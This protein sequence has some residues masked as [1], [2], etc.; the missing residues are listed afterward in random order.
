MATKLF[1]PLSIR[2]VTLRNRIVASPMWQYAGHDGRPNDWHLMNLG[3]LADGGSALVM[4]EGT[5]VQRGTKGTRGDIGIW[6]DENLEAYARIVAL[7]KTCGAIPG[8]QLIHP[9]R[10]ARQKPPQEGRG[11]QERTSDVIPEWDD[12]EVMGPS[13]LPV[14]PGMPL[15]REM[16]GVDIQNAVEAFAAAAARADRAGY[17]VL[18]LHGAH[19][20]L[21][22]SFLSPLS[23]HRTDRYG[24]NLQNRAR[25][26]LETVE[27]VRSQWPEGKPLFV[28][29]SC[30]DGPQEGLTIED[31]FALVPL[32]KAVGVDLIDCSSGGNGGSPLTRGKSASYGYQV[33]LSAAI[34][35]E[36]GILT[37]TVGLIVHAHQAEQYL[38]EGKADLIALA[39]ELIYNPN[40][41]MDAAL[42]LGE[43]DAFNLLSPREAFWLERRAATTPGLVPSTFA[44]PFAPQNGTK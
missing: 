13:P 9:G 42:K 6:N 11:P 35:R 24:G 25:I 12:W 28:R 3:R 44:D 26:L 18:E 19:G 29:L 43:D 39:R 23:N 5:T 2:D 20:Y 17:E 27:A 8:I 33:E 4:Q 16:T 10:K 41:P 15:P 31:T 14:G 21:L 37:A 7:M 30:I 34:R 38:A 22:H 40:W 36:T 32:L 1:S